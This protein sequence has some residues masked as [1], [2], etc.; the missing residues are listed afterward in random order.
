ME[1]RIC[2]VWP[3]QAVITESIFRHN[4][5]LAEV[6]GYLCDY[7]NV[8]RKLNYSVFI[9]DCATVVHTAMNMANI[10]YRNEIIAI[11]INMNNV[12]EAIDTAV[13]FKSVDRSRCIIA[14]GESVACSPSFFAALECFDYV[15]SGGQFE[16]G[17]EA[18]ICLHEGVKWETYNHLIRLG[19]YS[20]VGK[21]IRID[22]SVVLPESQWGMPKLDLIPFESYLLIGNGEM[23]ITACKGCPF[24]CEFCN[25]KYVSSNRI[26][27]RRIEDIVEFLCDNVKDIKSVY[28]D[29]STFSYN[30]EWVI[31]LCKALIKNK[32][33][34]IPWKTCTRLDCLDD[35]IIQWMGKANCKRISIGVESI[36]TE[37]QQRNHKVIDFDKLAHFSDECR[38][39]GI[40][41]RAL[42]IIGLKGQLSSEIEAA[43]T[44]LNEMGIQTRF[45]VLQDYEFMLNGKKPT[46]SDFDSLNRWLVNSP[47]EKLDINTVRKHEYPQNRGISNYP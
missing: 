27:Y 13:F 47:I 35:E 42:M 7:S 39:N 44:L 29:A 17:I 31:A 5:M 45:R 19:D 18:A 34:I 20:L 24:D 2:L 9:E 36:S 38:K 23:H 37:I 33:T 1:N 28:L 43:Q 30:R 41:P 25:E 11:A 46:V 26:R 4:S 15:V 6:A 22:S 3:P 14:Y 32:N 8:L 12:K 21:E 40:L 10:V 16:L